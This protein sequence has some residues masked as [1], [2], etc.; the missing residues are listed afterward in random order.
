MS[1]ATP[2][3]RYLDWSIHPNG[4]TFAATSR[5]DYWVT[6]AGEDE[7]GDRYEAAFVPQ[8]ETLDP[9]FLGDEF[10]TQ[11]EAENACQHHYETWRAEVAA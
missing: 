3:N 4:D 1:H 8:D 9:V 7:H 6:E 2:D 11:D 10:G 5:G